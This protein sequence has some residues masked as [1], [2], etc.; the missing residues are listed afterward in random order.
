MNEAVKEAMGKLIGTVRA[1]YPDC[2]HAA[3]AAAT[4]CAVRCISNNTQPTSLIFVGPPSSGKSMVLEWLTPQADL[5][6]CPSGDADAPDDSGSDP[7]SVYFHRSDKFT[8]ASFVSQHGETKKKDLADVDLL[9]KIKDKTLITP[10]LAPVFA[11]RKEDMVERLSMLVRVLDGQGLVTDAGTHGSRGYAKPHNFQWLG[12]TTPVSP[13]VLAAMSKL[14]PR[15]LYFSI[16]DRSDS[17]ENLVDFM[18]DEADNAK[19][20]RMCR[21]AMLNYVLTLY[22]EYPLASLHTSRV[23]VPKPLQLLMVEWGRALCGLR[24]GVKVSK[25]AYDEDDYESTGPRLELVDK[26]ERPYRALENINRLV[27][28]SVIAH[29]RMEATTYDIGMVRHIVL[30]SGIG[31]RGRALAAL[32]A[33][34]GKATSADMMTHML[35]SRPTALRYMRELL[36]TGLATNT[37]AH[38][39][40]LGHIALADYLTDLIGAPQYREDTHE[41]PTKSPTEVDGTGRESNPGLGPES[42]LGLPAASGRDPVGV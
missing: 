29:G 2:E 1:N 31:A 13:E 20:K 35:T 3:R 25:E 9:P 42:D 5:R 19:A 40:K 30:S 41:Q 36:V 10:E 15:I 12:A 37:D 22:R 18:S 38:G 24:V 14:G 6:G 27:R 28:A 11:G 4:V 7:L 23:T 39:G 34:G 17:N 32:I 26:P 16:F 21:A 8:A 33:A